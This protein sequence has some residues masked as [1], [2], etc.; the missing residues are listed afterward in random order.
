M[1]FN[2]C[3]LEEALGVRW[4]QQVEAKKAQAVWRLPFSNS[5][6]MV[7]TN[8]LGSNIQSNQIN[9]V[10]NGFLA[11]SFEG[12]VLFMPA[13]SVFEGEIPF[14]NKPS[15]QQ[16]IQ[17]G[18]EARDHFITW[19]KKSISAI[20]DGRF[21]KVVLSRTDEAAFKQFNLFDAFVKLSAAY[22][23][24]MVAAFYLPEEQVIWLCAT[25]EIL[26]QQNAEGIFKTVS[27]AGTQSAL[28]PNGKERLVQEASWT[29][30]EIEEQA[31]VSRYIIECFKRIRLREYIENGPKTVLAGNLMHLKSEFVVDT[32]ALGI[33]DL[34]PT[35]LE[36][37]HPTSAVC[38]MPKEPAKEWIAQAE[39]QKREMYSG[40]LGPIGF[41][42]E[43]HLFVNLRTVRLKDHKATFFAGCGITGDS[44]PEKEWEE[45][46]MK[47]RTLKGILMSS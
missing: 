23:N 9:Q 4:Q 8:G 35:M 3:T 13:D 6:R 1:S 5:F 31:Y 47:C 34:A 24:A 30:K 37:L 16:D 17:V 19:V 2:I 26:V 25:P 21:Q 10:G 41:E 45:T 27:L 22:P 33:K 11:A 18:Q 46:N 29:Q 39:L 43:T 36:M 40:Y 20:E 42:N 7:Q 38:G 12:Q 15:F 28:D 14:T 44:I 32:K